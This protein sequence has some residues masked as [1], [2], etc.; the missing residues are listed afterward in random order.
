M[1]KKIPVRVR[2]E[3]DENGIKH[4]THITLNDKTYDIDKVVA[5]RNCAS[6]RTGRFGERYTIRI[7]GAEHY[8]FYEEPYWWIL[9]QKNS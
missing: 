2:L 8:L 3:C 5:V 4:P 1:D 7:A 6:L 9:S